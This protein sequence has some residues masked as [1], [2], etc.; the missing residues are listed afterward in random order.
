MSDHTAGRRGVARF[1]SHVRH[2]VVGYVA[3]FFALTGS[4]VAVS[5]A[6]HIGDSAG[7]DLTGTYPNPSIAQ[8]AVNSGKVNDGSLIAADINSNN[9]DG[10]ANVPSLRTL[11]NGAQQA[12]AGNDSR[13]SDARTP[14]GAAGGDLAGTY[15]N[16]TIAD[17]AVGTA[18]L[19]STI[20]AVRDAGRLTT[21]PDATNTTLDWTSESYDTANLHSTSFNTSRFTAPVAGIYRVSVNIVW[22]FNGSG[23]RALAIVK[24]GATTVERSAEPPLPNADE[25]QQLSSE[26]Q[27]AAGDYVEAIVDQSTGGD[28][29]V[30]PA[31]FTMSW[32]A[33]G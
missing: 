1:R 29:G 31:S 20:P 33:P 9:K 5:P 32:A 6:L 25:T 23:F 22:Q 8:N 4:A 13:L 27:L 16:P 26:V 10:S 2:N 17:G 18:K 7:G 21:A 11:G 15:P 24:N 28:L 14:T 19:S 30:T 3:L 12:V